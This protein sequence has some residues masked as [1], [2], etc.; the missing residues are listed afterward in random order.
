MESIT[1]KEARVVLEA[2]L[3]RAEEIECPMSV[4]IVDWGRNLLLFGRH[5]TAKLGSIDVAVGKAY[6]AR[7]LEMSTADFAP[8]TQPGAPLFGVQ[9]T[10][11]RLV[12]FG[13]GLPLTRGGAVVG[14]VG[15]SGGSVEMDID[16]AEAAVKAFEAL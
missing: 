1:Y 13:G 11:S 10:D 7:S 5:E 2:A 4:A 9:A 15:V 3:R 16:C 14:A 12:A 8:L 6:T